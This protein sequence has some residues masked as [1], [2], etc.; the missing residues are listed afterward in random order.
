MKGLLSNLLFAAAMLVLGAAGFYYWEK[1]HGPQPA[2]VESPHPMESFAAVSASPSPSPTL[3]P[4]KESDVNAS[5]S[6]GAKSVALDESDETIGSRLESLF[7]KK[8]VEE[9]LNLNGIIRRFVVTV[10][11]ATTHKVPLE[12]S[13]FRSA[14]GEFKVDH[15]GAA[16]NLSERNDARYA[17]YVQMLKTVDA[18]KLTAI[19]VRYYSLFQQAYQELGSKG[20]FNDRLVAAIDDCLQAPEIKG[21]VA[22][23]QPSVYYKF[24]DPEIE[25]LSA[26]RRILLRS[27]SKN[28]AEIKA[29]LKEFRGKLTHLDE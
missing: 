24:A 22:L 26:C 27:G 4:I 19:Y 13:P 14:P 25:A 20:Y 10:Q 1:T 9:L 11:D 3:Y 17:P 15:D 12:F 7:G 21:A 2:P 28:E 16:L 5:P 6:P 8:K 23:V 29:K 18:D